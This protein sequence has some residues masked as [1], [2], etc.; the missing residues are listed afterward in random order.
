MD[1]PK[2]PPFLE[3][4]RQKTDDSL[5]AERGKTNESLTAAM[6]KTERQTDKVVHE[7]RIE[8]DEKL[9]SSRAEADAD[10]NSEREALGDDGDDRKN[11]DERLL[12]ERR[13][14]DN[15]VERERSRV[16]VAIDR[17]RDVKTAIESRLLEQEREQTDDN[18]LAERTRTDSEVH[19]ASHLLSD[20]IAE[21]S[22]TKIS[23]TTRDEFLA[24]V[25][26]DLRNPL[27]AIS[28]CTDML[29]ED[30]SKKM[31]RSQ[32]RHWIELIK[33][34]ADTSLR[35]ICDILDMESI[36]EGK[37]ELKLK[38]QC[39]GEIIRES[40]QSFVHTASAKT[41]LLSAMP[42][43]IS[44]S[45]VCDHDR[46][47]QVLSNLIGNALKFTPEGGSIILKANL[48]KT[49]VEVSVCDTGPGIPDNKKDYIFDRF[50]QLGSKDRTGLGL[51]LYISKMLIEAH[52][53]QLWVQSKVGEGS[54]FFF[55]LPRIGPKSNKG[56]LGNA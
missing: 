18:L 5:N 48:S 22:K 33:R 3:E 40:T 37:L 53:G 1:K 19:L 4:E 50:T 41:V 34:N 7:Q 49:A 46:I 45:V 54:T 15:A 51:G 29:L 55:S 26:H 24:I 23:L 36:A 52:Q 10:R 42:S 21:H 8:A 56:F 32:I 12:D 44:G 28:I 38:Q 43:N 30:S 11:D 25:S 27:G 9:S 31:P 2:S 20:E 14:A 6:V 17:E 13:R 16:D 39:I 35:L 47:M